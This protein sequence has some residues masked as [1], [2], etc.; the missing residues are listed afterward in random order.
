M[1]GATSKTL[2][3]LW[4]LT[5]LALSSDEIGVSEAKTCALLPGL[6]CIRSRTCVRKCLNNGNGY[7][8]GYCADFTCFCCKSDI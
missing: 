8:G 7:D 1:K 2:L 3:C 6:G 5:L 4:L